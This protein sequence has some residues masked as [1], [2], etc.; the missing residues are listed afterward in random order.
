M[1][2]WSEMPP[3]HAPK[4]PNSWVMFVVP[5]GVASTFVAL[6]HP[7]L[8]IVVGCV[9]VAIGVGNVTS[10]RFST[11]FKRVAVGLSQVLGA[12]LRWLLLAPF[13]VM[14]MA[15]LALVGRISSKDR[16]EL[17]IHKSQKSYWTPP[18]QSKGYDRPY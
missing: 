14:V 12:L 7:K 15:P 9:G 18:A 11:A 2:T 17:T 10:R 4:P 3:R 1:F 5:L 6:G 16:L 8:G 13:Y